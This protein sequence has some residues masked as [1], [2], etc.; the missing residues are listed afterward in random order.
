MLDRWAR[1]TVLER[2]GLRREER[3]RPGS[4]FRRPKTSDEKTDYIAAIV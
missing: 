2:D 3:E 4:G 1:W